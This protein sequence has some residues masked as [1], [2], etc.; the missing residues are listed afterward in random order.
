[1]HVYRMKQVALCRSGSSQ[2]LPRSSSLTIFAAD[3]VLARIQEDKAK[4]T[5]VSSRRMSLK[6]SKRKTKLEKLRNYSLFRAEELLEERVGS[7]TPAPDV[8]IVWQSRKVTV[9]DVDAFVQSK[10]DERGSFCGL[11]ANIVFVDRQR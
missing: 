2:I 9:N 3:Y 1:M 8:K 7:E 4:Y 10:D 11:F 6:I 5:C